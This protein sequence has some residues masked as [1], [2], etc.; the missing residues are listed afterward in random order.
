MV[1]HAEIGNAALGQDALDVFTMPL[2]VGDKLLLCSDGLWE[3]C[4]ILWLSR[5]RPSKR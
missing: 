1:E 5:H 3:M 4:V 2:Q